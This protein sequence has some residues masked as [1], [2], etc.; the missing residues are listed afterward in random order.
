MFLVQ[1]SWSRGT[2][3]AMAC[4]DLE[5]LESWSG[6]IQ[7]ITTSLGILTAGVWSYLIF[8]RRR[9]RYPRAKMSHSVLRIALA[10]DRDLVRLAVKIENTGQVLLRLETVNARIQQVVPV[11]AHLSEAIVRDADPIS[12]AETE[13]PWPVLQE[14]S[15]S[16][17]P[18]GARLEPGETEVLDCD[19]VIP[20]SIS[21]FLIY[22]HVPNLVAPEVSW[23]C[24]TIHT[25]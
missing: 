14:R 12:T 10:D 6:I 25:K 9:E 21:T 4:G 13:L 24:S 23:D 18:E 22:S 2:I 17:G 8:V 15:W 11:P 16:L 5:T 7:S 20:A 19:F 3:E 1:A